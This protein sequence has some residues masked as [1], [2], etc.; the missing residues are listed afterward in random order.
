M[1]AN[2]SDIF[3][4]P[5]LLPPQ[6][7]ALLEHWRDLRRGV[8]DMPF[9][10]DVELSR[11]PGGP[12]RAILLGVFEGPLRFRFDYVGRDI[13]AQQGAD[14]TG[15]FLD[16]LVLRGPLEDLTAQATAAVE[17]RVP[18]YYHH[19]ADYCRMLLPTWNDGRI[20]MLVGAVAWIP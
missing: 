10:D 5:D 7:G 19:R 4:V 3:D 6:I 17:R 11:L 9:S 8:N 2:A 18:R 16:E 15:K 20:G 1:G 13:A 12:S 14:V